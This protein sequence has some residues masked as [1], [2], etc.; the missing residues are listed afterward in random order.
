MDIIKQD[1]YS[2]VSSD[3]SE[4]GRST[5]MDEIIIEKS[6]KSST[7]DN[8]LRSV[9]IR[10]PAMNQVEYHELF[11]FEPPRRSAI[12]FVNHHRHHGRTLQDSGGGIGSVVS[13]KLRHWRRD[14]SQISWVKLLMRLIPIFHWLPKYKWREY[15]FND[16][17]AGFTV[18]VMH[19]PQ[20][21]AYAILA[22]VDAITGI[23]TAFFPVFI[24]ILFG[25]SRHISMGTFAV[26]SILVSK[27]VLEHCDSGHHNETHT[28]LS[29]HHAT[30]LS[31]EDLP[32][33][34]KVTIAVTFLVGIIQTAFGFMR[35]GLLSSLLSDPLVSGFTTGSAMHVFA[36][37][38]PPLIGIRVPKFTGIGRLVKSYIA[39]FENLSNVNF[40]S[41]GISSTCLF[42]LLLHDFVIK[43]RVNKICTFPIPIQFILVII[44]TLITWSLKLETSQNI[45]VVGEVPIGMPT[46]FLPVADPELLKLIFLDSLGIALI[47]Y[48]IS[49]SLARIVASKHRYQVDPNQELVAQGLSNIFG[50]F[51]QSL[52]MAGSLSRTMVQESTGGKTLVTSAVSVFMLL[53][54]ILYI[55]PLFYHLPKA[56]LAAII[57]VS[58]L[59]IFV[60]FR[61]L[62]RFAR[63]SLSEAFVWLTTFLFTVFLDVDMGLVVGLAVSLL[64][65]IAWGYF[66][67]IELVGRTEYQDLFLQAD[68]F[69]SG[70]YY[71]NTIV[72]RISGNLNMAN[73]TS[74]ANRIEGIFDEEEPEQ[75][76]QNGRCKNLVLDISPVTHVDSSA[77]QDIVGV[78]KH[79]GNL[80]QAVTFVG[81]RAEVWTRFGA[82]GVFE[83]ISRDRFYPTLQDALAC[84]QSRSPSL[85]SERSK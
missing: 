68:S 80:G 63:R 18:G 83:E 20:G 49:L 40:V 71:G 73:A 2:K 24:Y 15:L 69:H 51:F 82:C 23:Y 78:F 74:L 29:I 57:L 53:W 72:V 61:D 64:F 55:G 41:I 84:L 59:G 52:P 13:R 10:R 4:D 56:V 43:P 70:L 79:F 77:C 85:N 76:W 21:L 67:K 19:V 25:T 27:P 36:S 1:V 75:C 58:L 12:P 50:S 34:M 54:V 30:R 46:P 47:A 22:N 16:V 35:L 28:T 31:A 45:D 33:E 38:L 6:K 14:F 26:I 66:P 37:Q 65:L 62:V 11:E 48:V 5:P 42:I 81:I 44:G 60:Q 9:F 7:N 8:P 3:D 39:I 32:C 17:V